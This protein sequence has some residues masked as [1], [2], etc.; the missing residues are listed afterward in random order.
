MTSFNQT[1]L[2]NDAFLDGMQGTGHSL[3]STSTSCNFVNDKSNGFLGNNST[4]VLSNVST[5][6]KTAGSISLD[7]SPL[8]DDTS[9]SIGTKLA[10]TDNSNTKKVGPGSIMLFGK[11]IKPVGSDFCELHC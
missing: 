3:F 1:L 11:I 2:N 9:I 4:A 5:E 6:P 8:S 10:G 7:M